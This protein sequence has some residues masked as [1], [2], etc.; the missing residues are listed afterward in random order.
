MLP[1]EHRVLTILLGRADTHGVIPDRRQPKNRQ[2]IADEACTGHANV[3]LALAHLEKHGWVSRVRGTLGG[4]SF[5]R[6]EVSIGEGCDCRPRGRKPLTDAER[7]QRVRDRK[8]GLKVAQVVKG[9]DVGRTAVYRFYDAAGL[10][11]YVGITNDVMHRWKKHA[12]EKPWWLDAWT[13][14]VQWYGSRAEAEAEETRAI[15][16]ERPKCNIDQVPTCLGCQRKPR[17]GCFTCWEHAEL[18]V[19]PRRTA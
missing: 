10:L 2:V 12:A 6:Y 4:G 8:K 11:L 15:K 18:E 3:G 9:P 5:L 19:A 16:E 1:R 17:R 7:S 13:Q 14:T